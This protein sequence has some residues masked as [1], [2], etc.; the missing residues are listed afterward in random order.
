MSKNT[1]EKKS[2][3]IVTPQRND[4]LFGRGPKIQNYPGNVNY[5]RIIESKKIHYVQARKTVMKDMLA[6]EVYSSL[7]KM[8]PPG[9]FLK[10]ESDGFYYIQDEAVTL[11]KIK[12][13]LRENSF[14]TKDKID[15]AKMVNK[16]NVLCPPVP[17]P[18]SCG[19]ILQE[20]PS[21][22]QSSL[23]PQCSPFSPDI[24]SDVAAIS[25]NPPTPTSQNNKRQQSGNPINLKTKTVTSDKVDNSCEKS[26]VMRKSIDPDMGHVV[27]LL[28]N[29]SSDSEDR[30]PKKKAK[31]QNDC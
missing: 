31:R 4:V 24:F 6:R 8:T 17:P 5:R 1:S 30:S 27:K 22:T 10:K 12:Q 13:A 29:Q 25:Q 7:G 19:S 14:A 16:T 11:V 2:G 9:R 23:K 28:L 20:I 15:I 3:R 21:S 18:Y 26:Q